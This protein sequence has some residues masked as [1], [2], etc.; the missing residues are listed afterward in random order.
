M[1]LDDSCI[2]MWRELLVESREAA[3]LNG[4]T[5]ASNIV[6]AGFASS[7]MHR[8]CFNPVF[9][10]KQHTHQVSES[11]GVVRT[12][13]KSTLYIHRL[14][15]LQ[16]LSPHDMTKPAKWAQWT[17]Q[18]NPFRGIIFRVWGESC[19]AMI[20]VVFFKYDV[21]VFALVVTPHARLAFC[22]SENEINHW[23][24]FCFEWFLPAMWA[25]HMLPVTVWQ[26]T[27][28]SCKWV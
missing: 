6:A 26:T 25:T 22:F 3:G 4:T 28:L 23:F 27:F 21:T 13:D 14:I 11:P 24:H 17:L 16:W 18:I 7:W 9:Q 2:M 5:P 12:G 19:Q 8:L 10:S 20:C 15:A 1:S